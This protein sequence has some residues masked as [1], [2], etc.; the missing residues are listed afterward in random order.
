M[1]WLVAAVPIAVVVGQGNS[2]VEALVAAQ[3][4]LVP[5]F[6][7]TQSALGV[8]MGEERW[9]TIALM[10]L[11]AAVVPFVEQLHVSWRVSRPDVLDIARPATV[12]MN[13]LHRGR[14]RRRLHGTQVRSHE[15]HRR[16]PKPCPASDQKPAQATTS[17]QVSDS[18]YGRRPRSGPSQV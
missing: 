18:R 11:T 17:T 1:L 13:D 16:G 12:G 8:A 10:R 15:G 4:A 3:L 9:K 2:E 5:V 6:A 14:A 7:V